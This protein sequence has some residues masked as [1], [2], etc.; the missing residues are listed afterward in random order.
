MR[1]FL[2]YVF[3]LL[4]LTGCGASTVQLK[5]LVTAE[6]P[7]LRSQWLEA[8]KRVIERRLSRWENGPDPQVTVEEL[9]DG[10]VLFSFRTQN[11]E[12]RETMTQELLTPFS[13]RVMLASTDDTGDLFVE[14]QGWFNDTGLTQ[15]HILWT[16]SAADQDGKGVVRLVFSEEGRAL[17]RDVFQKNPAG[18]LGLF[19][20]D[21]LMSKMQIESSEPKEE[22][23]IT[24]IPV[25]DLAAIFADDV[26]VGTHITFSL[27]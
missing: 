27:P 21:K 8:G 2:P 15:A 19:V 17:L 11:T 10:S 7:T 13:L 12:A 23:T 6:D 5:A 18:I 20:R 25:P 16:E 22:I 14:E 4:T 24:G 9:S 1:R 3:L 26:N